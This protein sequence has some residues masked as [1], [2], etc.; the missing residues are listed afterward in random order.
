[1]EISP[2]NYFVCSAVKI[3]GTPQ[4]RGKLRFISRKK[5]LKLKHDRISRSRFC[6]PLRATLPMSRSM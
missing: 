5:L 1:M 6:I 3:R 2:G 4:E